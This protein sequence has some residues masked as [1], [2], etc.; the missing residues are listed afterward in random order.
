MPS[1]LWL[2][3]RLS[4]ACG[5]ARPRSLSGPHGHVVGSGPRLIGIRLYA[6]LSPY[7]CASARRSGTT[8]SK[9]APSPRCMCAPSGLVPA[10]VFAHDLSP[11]GQ[12]TVLPVVVREGHHRVAARVVTVKCNGASHEC[13]EG[14]VVM[15]D[16]VG[17]EALAAYN[18]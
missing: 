5:M 15:I 1:K 18:A 10:A 7:S 12:H 8:R 16:V 9:N 6:A 17:R 2:R 14:A 3:G 11:H 13:L 4:I